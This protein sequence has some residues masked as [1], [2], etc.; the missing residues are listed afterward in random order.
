MTLGPGL[1]CPR[2]RFSISIMNLISDIDVI[3]NRNQHM[4]KSPIPTPAT[5]APRTDPGFP[6]MVVMFECELEFGSW[7]LESG[8]S[9]VKCEYVKVRRLTE[10]D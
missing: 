5:Y 3:V 8:S 10:R 6:G 4:I 7:N 2:P 1:S 9:L